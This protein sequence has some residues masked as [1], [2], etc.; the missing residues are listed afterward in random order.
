MGMGTRGQ[1]PNDQGTRGPKDQGTK[2]PDDQGSNSL[3]KLSTSIFFEKT[4][5]KIEGHPLLEYL[6][7]WFTSVKAGLWQ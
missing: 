6:V 3:K 5:N 1:G 4:F 7:T 2:G